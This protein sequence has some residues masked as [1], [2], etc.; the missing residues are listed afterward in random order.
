MIEIKSINE[1]GRGNFSINY[2]KVSPCGCSFTRHALIV[3]NLKKKPTDEQA[4]K[5]IENENKG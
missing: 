3:T 2:T 1:I 5:L 4:L